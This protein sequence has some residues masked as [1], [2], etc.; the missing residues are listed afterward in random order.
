SLACRLKRHNVPEKL[1]QADL[2]YRQEQGRQ[3]F[4]LSKDFHRLPLLAIPFE[5]QP[6][7]VAVGYARSYGNQ[8]VPLM[9]VGES[10]FRSLGAPCFPAQHEKAKRP[11]ESHQGGYNSN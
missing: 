2:Q 10:F 7:P 11:G 1:V 4:Q 3:D 5:T 6:V 9:E 8:E